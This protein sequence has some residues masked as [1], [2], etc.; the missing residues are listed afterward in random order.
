MQFSQIVLPI[1]VGSVIGYFTNYIAIKMLFHPKKEI[2]LGGFRVPFTPGVI[3]KNQ[4]RIAKAVA[5]AV[6]EQ[7]LTKEDILNKIKDSSVKDV[8]AKKVA[9]KIMESE[10]TCTELVD[11][12]EIS[13]SL[14]NRIGDEIVQAVNAMDLVPMIEEI[15]Q[16]AFADFLKNP[17]IAMFLNRDLLHT[18]YEKMDVSIKE[19]VQ[20]NGKEM[21]CSFVNSRMCAIGEKTMKENLESLEI[22]NVMV[23]QLVEK[24]FDSVITEFAPSILES[25]DMQSMV[26]EKVACMNVDQLEELVMSV[27]KNELQTIINLGAL[28]GAVIGIVNIFI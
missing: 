4:K 19:Y 15:G 16:K 26:E 25:F 21:V 5:S 14:G 3:P 9:A 17:M 1:L 27:M 20:E 11:V 12:E 28:I 2:R 10:I 8:F 24:L 6:S 18:I 7:L 22:T 23:E 13:D